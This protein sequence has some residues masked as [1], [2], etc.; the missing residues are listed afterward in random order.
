M[1]RIETATINIL[2]IVGVVI[3]IFLVLIPIPMIFQYWKGVVADVESSYKRAVM[4]SD[5][6][7]SF[8]EVPSAAP[9]ICAYETANSINH[10]LRT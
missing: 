3:L 5:G 1:R 4:K 7:E 2:G 10:T 6:E 9:R 8:M